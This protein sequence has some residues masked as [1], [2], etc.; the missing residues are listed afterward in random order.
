[1]GRS[2]ASIA[3]RAIR[4]AEGKA[5]SRIKLMAAVHAAA[6]RHGMDDD[7]RREMQLQLTDKRSMADMTLA[8]LG[9]L[10]DHLNKGWKGQSGGRATTGKIRALW[11]TLYWLGAVADPSDRAIDGFVRRQGG[12]AS[13]RFV[14]H[15]AAQPI[16]EAL[17]SWAAREGVKWPA[18]AE[19]AEM[20]AGNPGLTMPLF[21]RHAVLRAIGRKLT[22][23]GAL[24]FAGEVAYAQTALALGPNHFA[25]GAHELD[26]AIRLLGKKHRRLINPRGSV[27]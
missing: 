21:E 9:K 13:L 25:W 10:L 17:K 2:F 6:K 26:A 8:D 3:G 18:E 11:W 22:E 15:R 23:R 14:D 7:D 16:I 5:D 20:Q 12:P 1:M 19:L 24:H 27:E 4:T